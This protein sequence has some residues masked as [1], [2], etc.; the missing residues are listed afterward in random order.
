M[1]EPARPPTP[2]SGT[3]FGPDPQ[4]DHPGHDG[5]ASLLQDLG[6]VS[7]KRAVNVCTSVGKIEGVTEVIAKTEF[8]CAIE[9]YYC[10]MSCILMGVAW[11]VECLL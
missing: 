1:Q 9:A 8:P 11:P 5:C 7:A 6:M 4:R 3:G 10:S 2:D